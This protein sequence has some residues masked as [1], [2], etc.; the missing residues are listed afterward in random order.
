MT[1]HGPP[2]LSELLSDPELIGYPEMAQMTDRYE[3]SL[4]TALTRRNKRIEQTGRAARTD[5][6]EPA[7]YEETVFGQQSPRW[8]RGDFLRW[9]MLKGMIAPDG[10]TPIPYRG[11]KRKADERQPVAA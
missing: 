9:A 1:A 5:I 7:D 4:R 8:R 6:P 10:V 3:Q 11:V 2:S